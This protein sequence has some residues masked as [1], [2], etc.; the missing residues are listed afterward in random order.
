MILFILIAM[1]CVGIQQI[2][3]SSLSEKEYM[4]TGILLMVVNIAAAIMLVTI[5]KLSSGIANS[6]TNKRKQVNVL[7]Q[8][9][10]STNIMETLSVTINDRNG[11]Y[12]DSPFRSI[13]L[14]TI[15]D[16]K[17]VIEEEERF[18]N[19]IV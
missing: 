15:S 9:R 8:M 13:V 2:M 18:Q 4:T 3:I 6:V 16:N 17:S 1:C 7:E 5:E 11:E 10:K 19:S 12:R 14:R